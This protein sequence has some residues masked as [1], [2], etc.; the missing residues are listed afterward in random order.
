MN[1]QLVFLALLAVLCTS[2]VLANPK[3]ICPDAVKF[4]FDGLKVNS[5]YILNKTIDFPALKDLRIE[6]DNEFDVWICPAINKTMLQEDVTLYNNDILEIFSESFL[7]RNVND[8]Y[9]LRASIANVRDS[10]IETKVVAEDPA[11][12]P[13]CKNYLTKL[14]TIIDRVSKG[15]K[16]IDALLTIKESKLSAFAL[17]VDVL[18]NA[19]D[20]IPWLALNNVAFD[21]VFSFRNKLIQA[22]YEHPLLFQSTFTL[23]R[24]NTQPT[25]LSP[26][27]TVGVQLQLF[28]P[29]HNKLYDYL[30]NDCLR[31]KQLPD[32][33]QGL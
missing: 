10:F 4:N 14:Q 1:H 31:L 13:D 6:D 12:I 21:C 27:T 20:T 19:I 22:Y 3:N 9:E 25:Y 28:I 8:F 17:P 7:K 2:S 18:R 30:S 5:V 15:Y 26:E 11:N 33:Y 29:L 24:G 23:N 32:F 16:F